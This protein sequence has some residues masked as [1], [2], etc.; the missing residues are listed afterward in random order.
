MTISPTLEEKIKRLAKA[1]AM[2]DAK[3]GGHRNGAICASLL[4]K[5]AKARQEGETREE[6][7]ASLTEEERQWLG[8]GPSGPPA[9]R[10]S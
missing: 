3:A 6:F 5:A 9:G 7:A 1:A 4:V 10:W 2:A 8:W